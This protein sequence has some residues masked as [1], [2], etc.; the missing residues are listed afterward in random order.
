M[1]CG[2][3]LVGL[4]LGLGLGLILGDPLYGASC[5][6]DIHHIDI[7]ARAVS[8]RSAFI[9]LSLQIFPF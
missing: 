7:E 9:R 2:S 1:A 4:G 6:M 5:D 3:W 8:K